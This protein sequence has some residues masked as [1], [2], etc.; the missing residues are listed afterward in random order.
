MTTL[1]GYDSV[2][3]A[4]GKI[5][6]HK[7]G[8]LYRGPPLHSKAQH[9]IQHIVCV[10]TGADKTVLLPT[11]AI[12]MELDY[13]ALQEDSQPSVGIGGFSYNF[14]G[15]AIITFNEPR[16]AIQAYQIDLLIIEPEVALMELPSLL[17]RDIL[18]Q[19]RMRYSPTSN[20][21]TFDVITADFTFPL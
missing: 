9:P 2:I 16:K 19:W 8:G 12:K 21:L 20:R 4:A 3:H 15:P 11:D 1:D 14:V 17:G 18:N 10:D 6:R 7:W 13:D 5:R